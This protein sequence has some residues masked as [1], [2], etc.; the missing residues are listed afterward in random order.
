MPLL[1][2]EYHQHYFSGNQC[3]I[4]MDGIYASDA[5]YIEYSIATNKAPIYSYNDTRFKVMAEGTRLVQGSIH[6]NMTNRNKLMKLGD[7][8]QARTPAPPTTTV[9]TRPLRGDA[10]IMRYMSVATDVDKEAVMAK[11]TAAYW[12]ATEEPTT[13]LPY[14][15]GALNVVMIF[16]VPGTMENR[17]NIKE[18]NDLHITGEAMVVQDGAGNII[19]QYPFF[20]RDI[21]AT[22]SYFYPRD[23]AVGESVVNADLEDADN[24]IAPQRVVA[25]IIGM[26]LTVNSDSTCRVDFDMQITTPGV[27]TLALEVMNVHYV[28]PIVHLTLTT[29]VWTEAAISW[30][31]INN[32]TNQF[33]ISVDNVPHQSAGTSSYATAVEL[34]NVIVRY[35]DTRLPDSTLLTAYNTFTDGLKYNIPH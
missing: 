3:R 12:G 9:D 7:R 10:S 32:T 22:V 5:L 33:R 2:D 11:Y 16:G 29:S 20:A 24:G 8:I 4:Y 19:L 30:T 25:D 18:I 28:K 27:D 23:E 15:W 6:M 35:S 1:I 14:D 13:L 34:R 31:L 17:Y 21:D 26:N